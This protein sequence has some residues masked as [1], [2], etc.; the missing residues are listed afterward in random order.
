MD[1][2]LKENDIIENTIENTTNLLVNIEAF[3][4]FAVNIS[5]AT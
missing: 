4:A 2:N 3:T 1:L 5:F